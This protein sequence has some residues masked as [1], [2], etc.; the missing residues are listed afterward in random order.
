M[1]MCESLHSNSP[2]PPL[3]HK[4]NSHIPTTLNCYITHP[5][6]AGPRG[7]WAHM[8][9]PLDHGTSQFLGPETFYGK[10]ASHS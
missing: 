7:L 3:E 10:T 6:V 1:A 5:I 9:D 2:L 8:D 4:H